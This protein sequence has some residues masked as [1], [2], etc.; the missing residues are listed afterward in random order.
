[1]KKIK[2]TVALALALIMT[3]AMSITAFA[4]EAKKTYSITI[5]NAV[6]GHTYEAYQILAGDLSEDGNT[7]SNITWGSGITSQGQ[8]DLGD[9]A[10]YA[11]TLTDANAVDEANKLESYLA[12]D[13][14]ATTNTISEGKYY[15]LSGLEAGYYLIKDMD[16]SITGETS[17]SYTAYIL[18]IAKDQT[19]KTKSNTTKVE[20]KVMDVN[21]TDNTKSD[22]QDSADYD[23]GDEVPF[24][25]TATLGDNV[26]KFDSY[27]V[28]FHD[29]LSKGL[30]YVDDSYEITIDGNKID[31]TKF[32]VEKA[33]N[34][35]GTALTFSCDDV[36][37][38]GATNNSKIVVT[39]KA[40]LN[41]NAFIGATG[42]PNEVYLEFSNN[43][44]VGHEGETGNTPTDKV[45]VFTYK[46][47]I[48]K[49]DQDKKAL[50]GAEFK[51]Y[52][53]IN[54]EETE[55]S[56]A[57]LNA[58][59][60]E[61]TFEG[62]DDGTYVLKETKTPDGYNTISPITFKIAASHDVES[63][64]PTL[65]DLNGNP[66]SGTIE[67]TKNTDAG[68]LTAD[69]INN[70]GSVLPSTGGAGRVAIYVIGAILVIGGG[71]VL[72]TKKRV[73]G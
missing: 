48:N 30:T 73:R 8:K 23:I 52:K 49:L 27:K 28:I 45:I 29:T 20:K 67:F 55:V 32:T 24:Q 58:D 44:N 66:V 37:K 5:E 71:I 25:L 2:Q 33:S 34:G 16:N 47:V 17:E 13:P 36:K 46:V 21:D 31:K 68:S 7:L 4:D 63:E 18:Q 40:T 65:T 59:G 53:I 42:N 72:V 9:A 56:A 60:T 50:E 64:N 38:L 54:N 69:V 62:L 3:F 19:I 70:K 57:K 11:G 26:E 22:W 6:S 39:Y 51:L 14:A 15:V 41:D 12:S 10:T 61:F 35:D 43:P 1:M